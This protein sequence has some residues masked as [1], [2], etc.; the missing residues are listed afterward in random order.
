VRK[1][2]VKFHKSKLKFQMSELTVKEMPGADALD[3]LRAEWPAL[4][5]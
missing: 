1:G 5:S 4:L 3:A 2:R